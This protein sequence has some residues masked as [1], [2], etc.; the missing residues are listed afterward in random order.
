MKDSSANSALLQLAVLHPVCLWKMSVFAVFVGKIS[1]HQGVEQ[2]MKKTSILHAR[3]ELHHFSV[4]DNLTSVIEMI[5]QHHL[6]V[7]LLL[8]LHDPE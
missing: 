5:P 2:G 1:Q 8:P 6:Q 4:P 7:R 3:P